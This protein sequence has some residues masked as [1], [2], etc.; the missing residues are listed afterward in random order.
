MADEVT[1]QVFAQDV[2]KSSPE[3]RLALAQQLEE[4]GFWTGKVSANFNINFYTSLM[5]L[6]EAVLQQKTVN[7]VLSPDNPAPVNR[8]DVLAEVLAEGGGGGATKTTTETYVTSRS[9]TSKIIDA[10]SQDL[11]ERK[12]TPAEKAKY[13]KLINAEQVRQP[14]TTT[15]GEGFR[16]TNGGI[17]EQQFLTEQISQTAEAKT[18]RATD[19]YTIMLEE[20]GGLR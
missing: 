9:A 8:Y 11:I 15:T 13:I 17:D 19:A 5:K 3:A 18:T 7:T 2:A 4:A 12:L 16:T 10:V 6:E 1:I 20:L 14:G